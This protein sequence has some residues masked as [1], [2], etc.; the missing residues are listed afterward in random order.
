MEMLPDKLFDIPR[1][2]RRYH[3]TQELLM[4]QPV[5]PRLLIKPIDAPRL[6]SETIIIPDS[7]QEE[8][9]GYALVLA[10]G[11][12]VTEDIKVADTIF[13]SK[14]AGAPL[15]VELD[16]TKLE[17]LVIMETDVLGVLKEN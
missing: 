3:I 12:A 10:V 8:K 15:T 2:E 1:R 13:V 9:S 4:L 5:G 11:K 6:T 16:G 17:A 14:Y 7:V